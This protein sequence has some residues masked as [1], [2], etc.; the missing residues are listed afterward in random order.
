M[1]G[2]IR[3]LMNA[4]NPS[5][6]PLKLYS[7]IIPA[8]DESESLPATLEHLHLELSLNQIPH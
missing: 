2:N 8:R 1:A 6:P 4:P 7:V 3:G 5:A